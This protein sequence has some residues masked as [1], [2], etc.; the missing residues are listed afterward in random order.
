[1]RGQAED[2]ATLIIADAKEPEQ[3]RRV[4]A[5]TRNIE[6][7]DY[8]IIGQHRKYAIERKTVTD[9]LSSRNDG[10][11]WKQLEALASMAETEDY[12]PMLIVT[13]N[14]GKLFRMKKL[15]LKDFFALQSSLAPYRVPLIHFLDERFLIPFL[16]YLDEK[17]GKKPSKTYVNIPKPKERTIYE[18]RI[19]VLAAVS[20]IGPRTA[21]K[22][23]KKYGNIYNIANASVE[24]LADIIGANKAEHLRQVLRG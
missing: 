13:G 21:E 9:L 3:Y 18:E 17:A 8:L 5:E 12:I 16:R 20:G 2:E 10:R 14:W 22:L 1:M 4:A 7:A 19:D 11:L 24:E 6:V 23:L 15:R